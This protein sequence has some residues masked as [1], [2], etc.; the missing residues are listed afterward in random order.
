MRPPKYKGRTRKDQ[1]MKMKL[2]GL[3]GAVAML[4]STS[5]MAD[6]FGPGPGGSLPDATTSNT[7]PGSGVFQSSINVTAQGNIVTFNSVTLTNLVHTWVGD[8]QAYIVA[9][10]GTRVNLCR[11]QVTSA[12]SFGSSNDL[13]GT[14]TFTEGGAVFGNGNPVP[15]GTYARSTNTLA[16]VVQ[17]G[18]DGATQGINNN[19]YASLVGRSIRG[20]WTLVIRDFALGDVGSLGSWSF[21]ATIPAPG[22]LALLGMAG[23]IGG[24]RRRRH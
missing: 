4:T 1:R 2:I 17:V 15:S 3:A 21:D 14:Y 5:A 11:Y 24:S 12:T 22:A 23:M 20:T 13:N 10:N 9:P 6:V 16:A 8:L 18:P 19:T 7:I